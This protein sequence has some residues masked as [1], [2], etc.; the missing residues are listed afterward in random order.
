MSSSKKPNTEQEN[1]EK[2]RSEQLRANLARRK[3]QTRS[4]RAG[5][6]DERDEGLKAA[7]GTE[8]RSSTG[9]S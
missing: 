8:E 1:R 2:R 6:P 9:E 4:R 5:A 3:Q 7:T